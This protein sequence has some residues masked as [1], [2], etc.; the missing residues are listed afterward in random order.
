[1]ANAEPEG[2]GAPQ[3]LRPFF[4]GFSKDLERWRRRS[5]GY[6][7]DLHRHIRSLVPEGS[8]V[9]EIG[10][11]QG[12]LL[13]FLG[14]KEAL[15]VDFSE[16]MIRR[17]RERFPDLKLS[18][19]DAERLAPGRTFDVVIMS[20]LVGYLGD[21]QAAFERA[22]DAMH[23]GSR[24]VITFHNPLWE[25]A[26]GIARALRLRSPQPIQNWLS[27]QDLDGLL[28]LAGFEVVRKGRRCLFP[29]G[30]PLLGPLV[31]RWVAPLPGVNRL[32][33]TSW[34]VARRCPRT[35]RPE[36]SVSIVVPARN[37]KGNIEPLVRRLPAFGKSRE[38]LFI[39]GGSSDGTR[40]EIERVIREAGPEPALR[41]LSQDGKGKGDAVR[42]AF[43]HATGD[44][45][46]ILDADLSVDP[47]VLPRFYDLLLEG[48]ADLLHGSRLVYPI[49]KQ[50]M[51]LLNIFGNKFFSAAFTWILGQRFKDTLCGTKVLWRSDYERIR[52]NRKVFGDFDPFGDYDLLF[53]AARLNLKISE[54]PV[55]YRSR[56]YGETNISRWR[57]GWLL[58]RM[59]A[60]AARRFKFV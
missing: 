31:N 14:E 53:G 46:M 11:G 13:A 26:F 6:Y 2:G 9:L 22:R 50:S 3:G 29:K 59:C 17:G 10:C 60:F 52:A 15:G 27:P 56:T 25:A 34:L 19:M 21:V 24:L 7:Q 43:E 4:D 18:V 33:L 5:R 49:E 39:E 28:D 48:R 55:R 32:C 54:V 47:E 51:R 12:D 35:R 40:E 23:D 41:L 37:E 30:V 16:E 36:A 57:H 38:V 20:N 8:S 44:V 45:L 1:M 42:K 58:L